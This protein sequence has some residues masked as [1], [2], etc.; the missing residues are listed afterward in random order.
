MNLYSKLSLKLL[1]AG[2]ALLLLPLGF[3]Q[4]PEQD[5]ESILSRLNG[6]DFDARYDAR[7][8]LQ[9]AVS[10]AS[11]PGNEDQPALVEA[12]LIG[13]L[14]S[15]ELLTTRL[16]IL[17]QLQLIGSDASIP[18][19]ENFLFSDSRELVD[20]VKMTIHALSGEAN[21]EE[22]IPLSGNLSV[23]VETLN[24]TDNKAIKAAAFSKIA[25]MSPKQAASILAE[26]PLP[27]YIRIAANS[28]SGSLKK[29]ALKR[30]SSAEVAEQIVVLGAL[31]GRVSSKVEA[32]MIALLDSEN[33]T[34]KLQTLEALG[35]VGTSRSL[36]AILRLSDSKSRDVRDAVIDT[37]ASINDPRLD[38]NLL[39]AAVNG[40]AASRARAVKAMSYRAS[41][42]VAELVNELAGDASVDAVLR[43][44]AIKAMEIVGN[45]NSLSILV[46]IVVDEADSG[47]RKEAQKTLKRMT[48]RLG[49]TEAAW[50]AFEVGLERADEDGKL[51]LILVADSAPHPKMI[52]YLTAAFGSSSSSIQKMVL[53]VLPAWRNWDGGHALLAIAQQE[54][55]DEKIRSQCF[56]GIGR[57]I[58]GSDNNYTLEGKFELINAALTAATSEAEEKAVLSGYRSITGKDRHFMREIEVH[59]SLAKWVSKGQVK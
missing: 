4:I 25:E 48:L 39:S 54:R 1:S 46:G 22:P 5:L 57:I 37:L 8:E 36:D 9:D 42:G 50:A 47:L 29:E 21:A 3:S 20:A 24:D 32:Q 38:K 51:A 43:E 44:E 13:L 16:W 10:R 15:E 53:R 55:S 33:S 18:P 40:D 2:I 59:P 30:L 7:M 56:K 6:A 35:R 26:S 52:D 11:S 12:Q 31:N 45:R 17:R 14:Q 28:R 49:D 41:N 27:E 19:L 34:L 58:L 23:L